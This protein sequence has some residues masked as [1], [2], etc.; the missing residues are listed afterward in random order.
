MHP[1]T[2][3]GGVATPRVQRSTSRQVTSASVHHPVAGGSSGP[4]PASTN[5]VSS[6]AIAG[7]P[8]TDSKRDPVGAT[9]LSSRRAQAT[10]RVDQS[11]D[12]AFQALRRVCTR[13]GYCTGP[14]VGNLVAHAL[15]SVA[16]ARR[17]PT[18]DE[19]R[20]L[21]QA[22]ERADA[23]DL[24]LV[25]TELEDYLARALRPE[26]L[27]SEPVRELLREVF[28]SVWRS[29]GQRPGDI[30]LRLMASSP[31]C[32]SVALAEFFVAAM[33][34]PAPVAAAVL[35]PVGDDLDRILHPGMSG[36]QVLDAL[37]AALRTTCSRA[38]RAHEPAPLQS[39]SM[40]SPGRGGQANAEHEVIGW[41]M[42]VLQVCEDRG[43]SLAG[44]GGLR[45]APVVREVV[46]GINTLP[47][48]RARSLMAS[49]TN[50]LDLDTLQVVPRYPV[51]RLLQDLPPT[52]PWMH[53]LAA[54]HAGAGAFRPLGPGQAAGASP[55][56]QVKAIL[57]QLPPGMRPGA[58]AGIHQIQASLDLAQGL[59]GTPTH[60]CLETLAAHA[61]QLND[62]ELS[63][64]V[65]GIE[66][67]ASLELSQAMDPSPQAS[68]DQVLAS[69]RLGKGQAVRLHQAR[70]VARLWMQDCGALASFP[71]VSAGQRL[72]LLSLIHL[73]EALEDPSKAQDAVASLARLEGLGTLRAPLLVLASLDRQAWLPVEAFAQVN[74]ALLD[75]VLASRGTALVPVEGKQRLRAGTPGA[76]DP[77]KALEDDDAPMRQALGGWRLAA[78]GTGISQP[79]ADLRS[80]YENYV[81]SCGLLHLCRPPAHLVP[82]DEVWTHRYLVHH[83]LRQIAEAAGQVFECFPGDKRV[84]DYLLEP[85]VRLDTALRAALDRL[86]AAAPPPPPL[87]YQGPSGVGQGP[88]PYKP[89]TF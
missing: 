36:Q 43:V 20:C 7:A 15:D 5:L 12:R 70:E 14:R 77:R 74:A 4:S 85:L 32:A 17:L 50:T 46:A 23:A 9:P 45:L 22:L 72:Q 89:A 67:V 83:V 69:G 3:A 29:P 44:P 41:I 79:M 59:A 87:R 25:A 49:L 53:V 8:R 56:T 51:P 30:P 1:S 35:R 60:A 48:V 40:A 64:A 84:T 71:G 80:F 34:A 78:G 2:S 65:L 33:Q 24:A 54:V 76:K 39:P 42:G 81:E 31:E 73:S 82:A 86:G 75:R 28:T 61:A 88:D 21:A 63:C 13:P 66:L 26:Q 47:A 18:R 55:W 57:D 52:T 11:A 19:A 27:A 62:L 38:F 6:L 68:W 58:L 37:A 10:R 16:W